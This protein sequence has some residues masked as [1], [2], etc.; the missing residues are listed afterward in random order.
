[1]GRAVTLILLVLL[2]AVLLDKCI[3]PDRSDYPAERETTVFV[4]ETGSDGLALVPLDDR[5]LVPVPSDP[6]TT[7]HLAQWARLPN[8]RLE[9]LTRSD[10]PSGATFARREID[11]RARTFRMLGQG[12]MRE[13]ALADRSDPGPM[14]ALPSRSNSADIAS[15]VCAKADSEAR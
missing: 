4:A 12:R 14:T 8:G 7:Y 15:F 11:C 10:G 13:E 9:A 2:G 3:G 6:G 5:D 1:M